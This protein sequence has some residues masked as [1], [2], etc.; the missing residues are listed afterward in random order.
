MGQ[1]VSG[2]DIVVD[3]RSSLFYSA[4]GS[5]CWEIVTPFVFHYGTADPIDAL[6]Y[7]LG[8]LAYL[9]PYRPQ[10]KPRPHDK[11]GVPKARDTLS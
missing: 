7:F 10:P 2:K 4:L 5:V 8:G 3:L 6:M 11:K 9:A 1:A